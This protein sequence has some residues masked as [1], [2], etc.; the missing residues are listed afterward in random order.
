MTTKPVALTDI[1]AA[2]VREIGLRRAVYPGRV[3]AGKMKHEK[4]EHEV[5]AME[6][7]LRVFD[8]VVAIAAAA[9]GLRD[10]VLMSGPAVIHIDIEK[11]SEIVDAFQRWNDGGGP[12]VSFKPIPVLGDDG[13][14]GPVI[15]RRIEMLDAALAQFDRYKVEPPAST[16]SEAEANHA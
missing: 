5:A 15:L 6:S 16:N 7:A 8:S 12:G 13:F 2:I 4:A 3:E 14:V 10:A 1:R 9:Q 11:A